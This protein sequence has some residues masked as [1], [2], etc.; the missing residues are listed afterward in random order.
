MPVA[1]SLVFTS[2]GDEETQKAF[3]EHFKQ[4]LDLYRNVVKE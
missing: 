3:A 1:W 4:E 2:V